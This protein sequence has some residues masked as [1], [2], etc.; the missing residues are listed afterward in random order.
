MVLAHLASA[1]ASLF[2][3]NILLVLMIGVPLGII[4]G[5]LPGIGATVGVT[6]L[7][8]LTFGMEPIVG[9]S[10]L[11]AVYCGAFYGGAIPAILINTPG[12]PAAICTILD[13]FPMAQKGEGGKALAIA[14]VSS[15][16]G[17]IISV[18]VL[19]LTA[20]LIANAALKFSYTEYFAI[21]IFGIVMVIAS[22]SRKSFLKGFLMGTFGLVLACVGQDQ[23]GSVERYTFGILELTRGIPL[24]PVLV[25]LFAVSQ[26]LILAEA[27][28]KKASLT[29]MEEK[30]GLISSF[31]S[32][33]DFKR[34]LFRSSFIGTTVGAIPGTGAAIAS[35]V[36][37]TMAKRGSKHPEKFGTGYPEGVVA[38]ESANN[39]VTGGALI[40]LLTLGI[41]GDPITAIMLGAFLAHGLIPGPNLFI[42]SA[43][44]VYGIFIVMVYIYVLMLLLGFYGSRLFAAVTGIQEAILVPVILIICFVGAY[45]LNSSLFD[46]GLSVAFGVL[47]YILLKLDFPLAPIVMGLILGPIAEEGLRQ[48]LI[49]SG[50]SWLIFLHH[51][52]SAAFLAITV[53]VVFRK[54]YAL[55]FT[56]SET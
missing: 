54:A 46:V 50:G 16:L 21:A 52:I 38:S 42:Q 18:V 5:V 24:L 1:F 6:V 51:P 40:P 30:Q 15:F 47:G 56:K 45:A 3:I 9:I 7:L 35:F 39:A 4:V 26:A 27:G 29:K 25:G 34:T 22:S 8:P 53:F 48:S 36:S 32:V 37:Y 23:M 17:G 31:K 28:D 44:L 11:V 49:V 10:M 20:P 14:V 33:L 12:T 2:D 41:P 55:V 43:D 19:S 13:G